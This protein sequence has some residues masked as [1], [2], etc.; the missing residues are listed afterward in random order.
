MTFSMH[1]VTVRIAMAVPGLCLMVLI[2]CTPVTERSGADLFKQNCVSCH[3][4]SGAGDGPLADQLPVPPAN[5]RGLSAA[6]D[7]VFPAERVIATM[8]GYRG[9]DVQGLMPEFDG[10][11]DGPKEPWTTADGQVIATP[12]ALVTLAG[13]LET[14]QDL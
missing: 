1:A 10:L 8:H 2:A 13:Y 5:L 14:L 6:N 7:G 12:T 9:K 3:G 4:R 11:L